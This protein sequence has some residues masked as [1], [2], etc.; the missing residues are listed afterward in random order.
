MNAPLSLKDR[1]AETARKPGT[2]LP[3]FNSVA[4]EVQKL[5]SDETVPIARIESTLLRDPAL[6]AQVLRMA[7]SSMYAG[8]SAVTTLRQ[9]LTR[10]GAQQ[11]MR[12]VLAAAQVSLYQSH[13]P[14]FKRHLAEMW[15]TA[16]ASAMGAAW[17]AHKSG[18]G[19]MAEQAFVAGLLHDVGKLVILRSIEKL[20]AEKGFEGPLPDSVAAEMIEALHCE[21]GYEL[22]QRW[23]L[24][25]IYCVIGRDHHLPQCDTGNVLMVAVRLI[26]QVCRKMGIGCKAEPDSM[27]AASE[28]ASALMMTDVALADLE[29]TLEDKLGLNLVGAA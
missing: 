2:H 14:L 12:L 9:A 29:V 19:E 7:N 6:S 11:I 3:V 16:Y 4:L 28:E 20:I 8:L 23:N 17:I 5:I 24:P 13:H 15:K 27:P 18:H 26:D 21:F 1:I 10:V 22:M 25:E